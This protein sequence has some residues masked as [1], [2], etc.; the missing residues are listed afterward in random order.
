MGNKGKLSPL[1][2]RDMVLA[3]Q[4][5]RENSGLYESSE[6]DMKLSALVSA[7]AE[8]I[9]AI[10]DRKERISL[11]DTKTVQMRGV[12]Y[13]RSCA[14]GSSLP[15][16]TGFS[17]SLGLTARALNDFRQKNPNHETSHFL[18]L[19]HDAMADLL[20]D[21][22]VKNGSGLNTIFAIF[23]EKARFNW[24]DNSTIEIKMAGNNPLGQSDV[25]AATIAARYTEL[26]SD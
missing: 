10:I 12:A 4:D 5:K 7:S 20:A 14:D 11:T 22:A 18:E 1:P 17:R 25:D 26:P 6:T 23:L 19:M 21:A 15:S 13:L 24:R 2:Y 8:E 16:M 3:A 9:A